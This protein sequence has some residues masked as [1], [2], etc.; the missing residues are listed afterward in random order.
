M[1]PRVSELG[2]LSLSVC[3]FPKHIS[4]HVTSEGA[5]HRTDAK[6]QLQ[7][8]HFFRMELKVTELSPTGLSYYAGLLQG[9]FSTLTQGKI[10]F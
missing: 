2:L 6:I 4:S 5:S 7:N 8:V 10:R 3:V 9:C 1:T